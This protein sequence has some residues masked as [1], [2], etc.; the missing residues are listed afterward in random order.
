MSGEDAKVK[1]LNDWL[2]DQGYK[3]MMKYNENNAAD[4]RI[5]FIKGLSPFDC[6]GVIF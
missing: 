6:K 3:K 1:V 5:K 4:N 2:N